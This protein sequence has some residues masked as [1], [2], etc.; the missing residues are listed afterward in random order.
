MWS[1]LGIIGTTAIIASVATSCN[2]TDNSASNKKLT[3]A[4]TKI[5]DL[6]AEIEQLKHDKADVDVQLAEAKQQNEALSVKVQE[7]KT[8]KP[9][10]PEVEG[11]ETLTLDQKKIAEMIQLGDMDEYDGIYILKHLDNKYN[12]LV[13]TEKQPLKI[14]SQY[15]RIVELE[16]TNLETIGFA[17]LQNL[18]NL[19]KLVAPMLV[20]IEPH[21]LKS[22][23]KLAQIDAPS[24]TTVLYEG[25]AYNPDLKILNTP[26]LITYAG[27]SFTGTTIDTVNSNLSETAKETIESYAHP[28]EEKNNDK[29]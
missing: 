29:Q 8:N 13:Y 21:G 14:E 28:D 23:P 10:T 22:N 15:T 2:E 4:Q 5:N 1:S 6:N 24:L 18:N 3:E 9:K 7:L 26:K 27:Y 12:K 16:L 19:K 17:Q 25:L 20:T 11:Y